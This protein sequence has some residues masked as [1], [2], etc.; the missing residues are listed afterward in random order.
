ME[1]SCQIGSVISVFALVTNT[2]PQIAVWTT[3]IT[4][5]GGL[6]LQILR[7]RREQ[8]RYREDREDRREV[9]RLALAGNQDL[10][11]QVKQGLATRRIEQGIQA[12]PPPDPAADMPEFPHAPNP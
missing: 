2:D 4:V 8:Q 5:A 11:K 7:D 9:A 10:L 12:E 6:L 1:M 3:A